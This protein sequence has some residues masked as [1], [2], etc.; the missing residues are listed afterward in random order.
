[1]I[2]FLLVTSMCQKVVSSDL[3]VRYVTPRTI[4]ILITITSGR[5]VPKFQGGWCGRSGCGSCC[6]VLW[7]ILHNDYKIGLIFKK[8]SI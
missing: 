2:F 8:A 3:K 6:V 5:I 1:M 7:L 4:M